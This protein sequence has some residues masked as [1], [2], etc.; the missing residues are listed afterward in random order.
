MTPKQISARPLES[1]HRNRHKCLAANTML[2]GACI[3]A[4]SMTAGLVMLMEPAHLDRIARQ[5]P[6]IAG[7][8][9]MPAAQTPVPVFAPVLARLET[10][11]S[12]PSQTGEHPSR[13]QPD[14]P[15]GNPALLHAGRLAQAPTTEQMIY[16]VRATL[17]ALDH[18]NR[19][20]NDTVLRELASSNFQLKNAAAR[21]AGVFA[22]MRHSQI[23]MTAA[24][25]QQPQWLSPPALTP[26]N[27]L[28][29][30]GTMPA[31]HSPVAFDMCFSIEGGIW[32]LDAIEISP[33]NTQ[34]AANG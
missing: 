29:L 3:A 25:L 17:I 31:L 23:D 27:R 14:T 11:S 34:T 5:R 1:T 28:I 9:I 2:A 19:T 6:S 4:A 13:Q 12:L 20:D 22:G 16:L 33:A 15:P 30:R 10:D 26:G 7:F 8:P 32:K 24:A 18:A 21:L